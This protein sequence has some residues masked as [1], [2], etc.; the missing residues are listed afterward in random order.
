LASISVNNSIIQWVDSLCYLGVYF[1]SGVK[2]TFCFSKTKRSFYAAFNTV[3]SRAKSL[4]QL[5]Q[6]SLIESQCCS[7]RDSSLGLETSRDSDLQVL[8][9]VLMSKVLVL[10]LVLRVGVLVLVSVL[11]AEV[12]TTYQDFQK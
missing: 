9:L 12:L 1:V 5:L 8:V 10:V 3:I 6:L 11:K 4:D 2:P 7:S